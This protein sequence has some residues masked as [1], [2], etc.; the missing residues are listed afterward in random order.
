MPFI[1]MAAASLVVFIFEERRDRA[2]RTALVIFV[3]LVVITLAVKSVAL[4][5]AFAD[6]PPPAGVAVV[7]QR[8]A[9]RIE[10]ISW[11]HGCFREDHIRGPSLS[12]LEYDVDSSQ[13]LRRLLD[14][15]R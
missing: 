8:A 7:T 2:S 11:D 13:K 3:V 5:F 4:I 14:D 15:L 9:R 12:G 10:E 1:V 6:Q